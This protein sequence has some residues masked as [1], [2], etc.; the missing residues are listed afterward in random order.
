MVDSNTNVGDSDKTKSDV[1]SLNDSA[2]A[3]DVG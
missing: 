2:I 1:H 3:T